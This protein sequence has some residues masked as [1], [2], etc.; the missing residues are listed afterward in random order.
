MC[1][2]SV[3]GFRIVAGSIVRL[4]GCW[5]RGQKTYL[6]LPALTL[7]TGLTARSQE[8]ENLGFSFLTEQE[9]HSITLCPSLSRA[10]S[11]VTSSRERRRCHGNQHYDNIMKLN[12]FPL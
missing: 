7:T 8:S 5:N 3:R 6:L 11:M 4:T 10:E 12:N 2:F 9:K 1:A